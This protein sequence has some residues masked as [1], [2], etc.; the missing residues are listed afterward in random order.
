M[1]LSFTGPGT[2]TNTKGRQLGGGSMDIWERVR[3]D[4]ERE[5]K[6]RLLGEMREITTAG[7]LEVEK[8]KRWREVNVR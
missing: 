4:G 1:S 2:L 8:G 5:R 3:G 7:M 6:S